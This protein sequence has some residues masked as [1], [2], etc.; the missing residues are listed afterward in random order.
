MAPADPDL[1][2]AA[3]SSEVQHPAAL[4]RYS[5]LIACSKMFWRLE[6]DRNANYIRKFSSS[7]R[8]KTITLHYQN[9][10]NYGV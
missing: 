7:F 5:L 1:A 2:K 10:P 4:T 3:V 9:Q 6:A 8:V